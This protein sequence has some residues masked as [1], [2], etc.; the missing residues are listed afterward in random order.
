MSVLFDR[1]ERPVS[2]LC[3]DRREKNKCAAQGQLVFHYPDYE[4]KRRGYAEFDKGK[5]K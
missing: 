4:I 5:N 3:E 2:S 1:S